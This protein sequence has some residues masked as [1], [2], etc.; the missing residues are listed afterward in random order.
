MAP[1]DSANFAERNIVFLL[2]QKVN[3]STYQMRKCMIE[4]LNIKFS[5][6]MTK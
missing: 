4:R 6:N 3:F 1:A 2:K 5:E